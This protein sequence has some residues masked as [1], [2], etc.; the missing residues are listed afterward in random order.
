MPLI[1]YMQGRQCGNQIEAKFWEVMANEHEI[2]QP[3]HNKKTQIYSWEESMST[4]M[5]PLEADMCLER[6]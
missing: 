1:G 4:L 5:K 2:T 6:S 3:E